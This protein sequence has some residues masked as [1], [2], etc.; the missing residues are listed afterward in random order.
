MYKDQSPFYKYLDLYAKVTHCHSIPNVSTNFK[1]I[2]FVVVRA[3]LEGEYSNI[4]HE[5]YPGVFES[6]KIVTRAEAL[7][8]AKYA[9]EHAYLTGRKKVS[10]IHK[11]NIMKLCDGQFLEGCR[12]VAADFPSIKYEEVIVDNTSMQLVKNPHQ[13]DVMVMPNLYGSIIN[14]VAAG[15]VGSAGIIAGA[16]FGP[17]YMVFEQG[18]RVS[19]ADIAGQGIANPTAMIMSSCNMLRC[20]GFPRFGD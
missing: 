17:E 6:I 8:V 18:S 19:G 7:R 11:A 12:E 10:A 13:F 2:D 5:V 4:E 15:I 14:G 1:D 3:G 16:N 20:I 9:F